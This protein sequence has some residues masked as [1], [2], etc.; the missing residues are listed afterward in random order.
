MLC[1]YIQSRSQDLNNMMSKLDPRYELLSRK[2]FFSSQEIP[3]LYLDVTSNVMAELRQVR[4]YAITTDL[5]TSSACEP[6]ITLTIH[7]IAGE[8]CLQSNCLNTVALFAD[9]T[10]DNIAQSITDILANWELET[11]NLVKATTDSGA[12]PKQWI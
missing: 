2:F 8:W 1:H 5:W 4:Y 12:N 7:Y 9:H 3:A 10:G 6:Y 11:Q